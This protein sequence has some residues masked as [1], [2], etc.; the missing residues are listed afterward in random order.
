MLPRPHPQRGALFGLDAR[1]AL[2]VFGVVVLIAGYTAFGRLV[3]AKQVALVGELQ[4]LE[5]ALAHYQADLGTF[6]PFT[7]NKG[8]DDPESAEDLAALWDVSRVAPG[9]QARWNGPYVAR[10]TL[11]SRQYGRYGLFYAQANREPCTETTDCLLWLTLSRVPAAEWAEVNRLLDEAGG[12][13][14]EKADEVTLQGRVQADGTGA[15]RT[16]LLQLPGRESR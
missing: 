1:L 16:L 4:G 10:E 2:V 3:S 14:P 11:Q 8:I 5:Q 6:F 7:L 15:E 13:Y 12:K 9:F